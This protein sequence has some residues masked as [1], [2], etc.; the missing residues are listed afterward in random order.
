MDAFTSLGCRCSNWWHHELN[1]IY[2]NL[3][4]NFWDF[5]R[6]NILMMSISTQ[7]LYNPYFNLQTSQFPQHFHSLGYTSSIHYKLHALAV[8]KS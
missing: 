8:L 6:Q 3:L 5:T 4:N 1:I 2:H 7:A